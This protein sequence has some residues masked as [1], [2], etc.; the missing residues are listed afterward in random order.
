M[1]E[2]EVLAVDKLPLQEAQGMLAYLEFVLA[3]SASCNYVSGPAPPCSLP[4]H[5]FSRVALVPERYL[6]R[7]FEFVAISHLKGRLTKK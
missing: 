1:Q 2:S 3:P 7:P 4:P 5:L 6:V